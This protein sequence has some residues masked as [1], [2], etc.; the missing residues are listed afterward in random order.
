MKPK[1]AI[2]TTLA[3]ASP[4]YSLASIILQQA[5]LLK[6]HG[7]ETDL[8]VINERGFNSADRKRLEADPTVDVRFVLP[9]TVLLDYQPGTPPES[10]EEAKKAGRKLGFE[11]QAEVHLS[12]DGR[13]PGFMEALEPYDVVIDHDIMFLSWFLPMNKAL[14]AVMDARP[15]KTYLHWVHSRP[16]DAPPGTCYPST[17]RYESAPG[18]YVYLNDSDR[19]HVSAVYKIPMARV[20]TVYNPKDLRD[21]CR[22]T[23]GARALIDEYDL[24]DHEV[25]QAYPFST[26][27]WRE[28]GVRQLLRIWGSWRSI[29]VCARLLLVTAHSNNEVDLPQIKAIED[30]A[31]ACGL[32]LD[33]DVMLTHR[34]AN[35]LEKREPGAGWGAWRYCVPADVVRDLMILANVFVF[36]TSSEVCSLVQAEAAVLGCVLVLN[37]DF[38]PL[39]D[40]ATQNVISYEFTRNDPDAN[41]GYYAAVARELWA[42]LQHETAFVNT[43][44]AR[45]M[46]DAEQIF[47]RQIE[48]LLWKNFV[49]RVAEPQQIPI[50]K[51]D[52]TVGEPR[53]T[54]NYHDPQLGDE[55]PIYGNCS[56]R[57]R[58]RCY[59]DAGH[60]PMLD[61]EIE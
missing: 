39:G 7:Y 47:K 3:D 40:F 48:P 31:R 30:Y 43:T 53:P 4:A 27:R 8:L 51:S 28:K 37:R 22:F 35:L 34:F 16:S 56:E 32:R 10:D 61:E 11:A 9:Q 23:D 18:T 14:R 20:A 59:A 45:R 50:V 24:M 55:C 12:G 25:L 17:L 15:Q 6:A 52:P 19:T 36:P 1:I 46:H 54:P 44:R 57:G 33:D 42:N 41:P 13:D 60:C 5:R 2:L 49:A 29:G 38:P 26:P 21:V 58:E